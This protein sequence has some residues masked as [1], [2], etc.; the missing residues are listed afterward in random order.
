LRQ[1][2]FTILV[3]PHDKSKVKRLRVPQALLAAAIGLAA[4]AVVLLGV[5]LYTSVVDHI[6]L[7][8]VQNERAR[9][10][11]SND[12]QLG[13]IKLFA[14][15]I[16]DIEARLEEMQALGRKLRAMANLN[17]Q[18]EMATPS[19]HF[20]IGGTT[21]GDERWAFSLYNLETALTDEM[22]AELDRLSLESSL[23]EQSLKELNQSFLEKSLRE[24]HTPAI[25]PTRGLITSGYGE[26]INPITRRYQ[27]PT[28]V[29]VATRR[30]TP[31][32]STADGIIVFAGRS[33]G[34]GK[35]VVVSHGQ[36]LKTRYAHLSETYV[37]AGQRVT[38]G[39]KIGA[40]G[41]T[42]FTTGPHLHYEVLKNGVAVN[43]RKFIRD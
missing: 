4:S 35:M 14:T 37:A 34:L 24:A 12:A 16:Q 17:E 29:D 15:R 43:P 27:F 1:K 22:R 38:R 28:G 8:E 10:E 31:V 13:Q 39:T 18:R 30:G 36:G 3:V 21:L 7:E 2:H 6:R 40:T 25:W 42:G 5:G 26:R 32:Y 11:A 41:S 33:G 9:L 23:Q 20:S 19:P